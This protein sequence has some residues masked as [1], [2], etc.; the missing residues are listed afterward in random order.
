MVSVSK[1]VQTQTSLRRCSRLGVIRM[2]PVTTD[3]IRHDNEMHD[4]TKRHKREAD[5]L[6][7]RIRGE[8]ADGEHDDDL[9]EWLGS[10]RI[11]RVAR[12]AILQM[13][14]DPA[15]LRA[16]ALMI[17]DYIDDVAVRRATRML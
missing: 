2:D 1:F 12:R 5:R 8:V 7:P 10:D 4:A 14:S 11:T 13:D 3:E 17:E 15:D 9:C 6:R 16:L